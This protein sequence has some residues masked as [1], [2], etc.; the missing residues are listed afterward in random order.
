VVLAGVHAGSL[1][2]AIGVVVSYA[3]V[4]ALRPLLLFFLVLVG[5]SAVLWPGSGAGLV[6]IVGVVFSYVALTSLGEVLDLATTPPPARV[7]LLA[8]CLYVCHSTD[9]L[10]GAVARSVLDR[11][12]LLRWLRRLVEA[13]VPGLAI[14]VVV[15][16]LPTG[17]GASPVWLLGAA[18]V[19]AAAAVP[20]FR[21]QR[22][23]WRTTGDTATVVTRDEPGAAGA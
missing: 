3:A 22:R 13:L 21:V 1:A 7:L 2:A 10:R 6:A 4:T 20:A 12:V 19:L 16:G 18:A 5:V 23:P 15:L 14:G 9:A 8:G 17:N 11:S